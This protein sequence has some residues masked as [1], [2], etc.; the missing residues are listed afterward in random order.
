MILQKPP[1]YDPLPPRG[2]FVV[3]QQPMGSEIVIWTL[4]NTNVRNYKLF[5]L[6]FIF[7]FICSLIHHNYIEYTKTWASLGSVLVGVAQLYD[8]TIR[9]RVRVE[10]ASLC[11]HYRC[12]LTLMSKCFYQ[13]PQIF[14]QMLESHYENLIASFHIGVLMF[15]TLLKRISSLTWP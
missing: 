15:I 6:F 1:K 12:Q 11:S 7:I 14:A 9:M 3:R 13:N 4:L 10:L 5:I 8:S 2:Y